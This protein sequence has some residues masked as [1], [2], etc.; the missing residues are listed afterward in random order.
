MIRWIVSALALLTMSFVGVE[1]DLWMN[2][3]WLPAFFDKWR[4]YHYFTT[5]HG[6]TYL[7]IH[8]PDMWVMVN[9][10]VCLAFSGVAVLAWKDR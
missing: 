1:V 9:V 3:D 5:D 4:W 7:F 2:G 10:A 8:H 6:D